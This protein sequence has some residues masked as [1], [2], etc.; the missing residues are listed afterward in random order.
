[1][2]LSELTSDS[3]MTRMP[4]FSEPHER[5]SDVDE[6]A[7]PRIFRVPPE[8]AGLRLD[9][10]MQTQLNR[11]SRTRTQTI[12]RACAYSP[13]GK[14]LRPSSRVAAEQRVVLWR[15]PWDENPVPTELP[16]VF[17]DEHYLV[18]NKPPYIPVHPSA[19]YFKNTVIKVLEDK[20]PDQYL[21][22]VHRIDRETSGVLFLSKSRVSDRAIKI[23]FEKR[24]GIQK[25]YQAICWGIPPQAQFDVRT[26][27][28]RDPTSRTKVRMRVAS[29]GHG[30][31]AGTQFLMLETRF[32]PQTR[33]AYT[34]LQCEL[35]TGRQH[36]IRVHLNSLGLPIVGDKLYAFDE[37]YFMRAVDGE[38]TEQDRNQL[39]LPRHALHASSIALTHPMTQEPLR[40]QAPMPTDMASFWEE[41]SPQPSSPDP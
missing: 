29:P 14:H 2:Y 26:P 10:F 18:I 41:L 1:M 6:R 16:I 28:E 4:T 15:P 38:D 25:Q 5:P 8:L 22:L 12:V 39:E 36:Q 33:K 34:L 35:E 27:L 20:Y 9:V 7:I 24:E 13:E 11:T 21:S 37:G 17:E 32:H 30:L 19:R 23:V 40:I 31:W 3:F